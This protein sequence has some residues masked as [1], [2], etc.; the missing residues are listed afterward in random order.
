LLGV[1]RTGG[2]FRREVVERAAEPNPMYAV[3]G[4][5]P[6]GETRGRLSRTKG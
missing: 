2:N 6:V 5:T 3:L 1:R 4:K